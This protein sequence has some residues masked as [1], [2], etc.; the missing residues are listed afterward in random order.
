MCVLVR[1]D[2][3]L[4]RADSLTLRPPHTSAVPAPSSGRDS[5][6]SQLPPLPPP[7][8]PSP[9]PLPFP[10]HTPPSAPSPPP[11]LSTSSSPYS[12]LSCPATRR[13]SSSPPYSSRRATAAPPS[14]P[15]PSLALPR[16]HNAVGP[17]PPSSSLHLLLSVLRP[18]VSGEDT[19]LL[20]PSL[21][22]KARDSCSSVR[23]SS[24]SRP[25][26]PCRNAPL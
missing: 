3:L 21:L 6:I 15:P 14:A 13:C 12:A 26:S 7:P 25:L 5:L 22:L 24:L 19:L 18:F 1:L 16:A 8:T 23:P 9:P 2:H 11:P 10:V 4:L 17:F 20:L